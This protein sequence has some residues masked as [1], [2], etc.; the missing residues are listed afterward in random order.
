MYVV[1]I[2]N[3]TKEGIGKTS[4]ICITRNLLNSWFDICMIY[5][6]HALILV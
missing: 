4:N 5:M 1:G 3:V 6:V 2:E